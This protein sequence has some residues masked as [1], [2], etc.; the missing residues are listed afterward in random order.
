MCT[1]C[2]TLFCLPKSSAS[3]CAITAFKAQID[4]AR[5][6]KVVRPTVTTENNAII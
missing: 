5:I 1:L 2:Y 3:R 6:D 4:R